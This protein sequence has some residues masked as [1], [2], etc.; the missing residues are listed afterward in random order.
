MKSQI[1]F[2]VALSVAGAGFG[3]AYSSHADTRPENASPIYGVTLPEGYRDGGSSPPHRRLR[4]S[5]SFVRFLQTI[6]PLTP[7]RTEPCPFPMARYW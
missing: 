2:A 3:A 6:S 7:T 5:T 4:H 1:F